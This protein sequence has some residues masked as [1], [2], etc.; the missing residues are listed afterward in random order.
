MSVEG[1]IE[2]I[3]SDA[4]MQAE[5]IKKH[6]DQ[7]ASAVVEEGKQEA[8]KYFEKQKKRLEDK[9]NQEKEH[10]VLN[11]RLQQR[12]QILEAR[13]KWMDAAFEAAYK[14]LVKQPFAD[15]RELMKKLILRVTATKDETVVFGAKGEDKELKKL[16][17]ELN[18]EAKSSFTLS[19]E[20][21]GF[22]WGFIL[23]RGKIET[24]MS[25]DSLFRYKRNDLEQKA[26]ELFNAS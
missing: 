7:R 24:S 23:R 11:R 13:Q 19:K 26:W 21:G 16:I 5:E 17:D 6:A 14:K 1:I 25:I 20:R 18:S 4:Q 3:L 15:Y 9:Y 12:K 22:S 10:A 2:R 8:E